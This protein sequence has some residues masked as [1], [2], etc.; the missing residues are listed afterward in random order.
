MGNKATS[1]ELKVDQDLQP[2]QKSQSADAISLRTQFSQ[3][4]TVPYEEKYKKYGNCNMDLIGRTW[5]GLSNEDRAIIQQCFVKSDQYEFAKNVKLLDIRWTHSFG[6][7]G[8]KWLIPIITNNPCYIERL[9]IT[10]GGL[11]DDDMILMLNAFQNVYNEE[12]S[13]IKY[14]IQYFHGRNNMISIP[15]EIIGLIETYCPLYQSNLKRLDMEITPRITENIMQQFFDSIELYFPYLESLNFRENKNMTDKVCAIIKDFYIKNPYHQLK[16]INFFGKNYL[17]SSVT[18]NG[19]IILNEMFQHN[20]NQG[21]WTKDEPN[22]Y[23]LIGGVKVMHNDHRE[24]QFDQRMNF[25]LYDNN[26]LDQLM[27]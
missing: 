8:M 10:E 16:F 18:S 4:L 1:T 11:C 3:Y 27:M 9:N 12:Q 6:T 7:E 13:K 19:L 24:I 17:L 23:F 21:I 15:K 25:E 14:I 2:N 20:I 5:T 26:P 22:I